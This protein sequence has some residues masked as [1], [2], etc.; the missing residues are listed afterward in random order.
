V[1]I[2]KT[3]LTWH[4][5]GG[6]L[7]QGPK[8]LTKSA[9]LLDAEVLL[10]AEEDDTSRSNEPCEVILLE[11]GEVGQVYAMDLCSNLGVVV[12]DFGSRC[13]QVLEVDIAKQALIGVGGFCKSGPCDV[14]ES[15]S[16]MLELVCVV[17]FCHCCA[18]GD[19]VVRICRLGCLLHRCSVRRVNRLKGGIDKSRC[20]FDRDGGDVKQKLLVGLYARYPSGVVGGELLLWMDVLIYL[21]DIVGKEATFKRNKY[22]ADVVEAYNEEEE[23]VMGGGT[24]RNTL[25]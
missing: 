15:W 17:V 8:V 18:S 25:R 22:L 11:V 13:Q 2:L 4:S 21:D 16:E 24:Y 7:V 19:V 23:P 12:E 3:F 10:I 14:R 20:H 9:L 1:D 6:V 5:G